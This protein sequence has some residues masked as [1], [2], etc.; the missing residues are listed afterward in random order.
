MGLSS[1]PVRALVLV[2]WA[3]FFVSLWLGGDADR[4]LGPRTTWV[5]PFGAITLS[6]AAAAY[7]LLALRGASSRPVTRVEALGHF[8]LLVPILAVL[9]VPRAE[10]GAQAAR[11]K[12]TNRSIAAAQISEAKKAATKA[13][14]AAAKKEEISKIDFLSIA[15]ITTDPR[16]AGHIGVKPGILVRFVGFTVQT[17]QPDRFR[18]AR[19]LISCC[20][21]DAVPVFVEVDAR[22]K[23]IPEDN[24]WLQVTGR[25]V[26]QDGKFVVEAR[27]LLP[28]PEPSDPYLTSW[29]F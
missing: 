27:E 8:A 5:V 2:A 10:L 13:A 15:S 21:A 20:A 28:T 1:R 18:L 4:Y 17:Y 24:T 6:L 9:V 22:G 25:L 23:E 7:G 3:G 26:K 11:K 16:Y 12:D 19:F 29:D 14:V